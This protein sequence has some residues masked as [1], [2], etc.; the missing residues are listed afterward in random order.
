M[1]RALIG[2]ISLWLLGIGGTGVT[3]AEPVVHGEPHPNF[4]LVA[5]P[6]MP[7]PRFQGTVIL[8]THHAGPAPVGV[9]L[10]KPTGTTLNDIFY[11]LP[12][13]DP[14]TGMIYFGGPVSPEVFAFMVETDTQPEPALPIAENVYL[15]LDPD[16]LRNFIDH[17]E[18][19]SRL[20]VFRGYA[21]WAPG[22]LKSEISRGDWWTVPLRAKYLFPADPAALWELIVQEMKGKWVRAPI[23]LAR[24]A[25]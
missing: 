21:G 2:L 23:P 3:V 12:E 5:K 16:L 25:G 14:E 17:P 4:L 1:R 13:L 9:I 6:D 18:A 19:R 7:D 22:Q 10:N 20:R 15:G 8:I 24:H 11:D